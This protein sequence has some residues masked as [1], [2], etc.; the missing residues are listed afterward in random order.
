MDLPLHA[1]VQRD[2]R[3]V[4]DL[5]E[6]VFDAVV[7]DFVGLLRGSVDVKTME[8]KERAL[9]SNFR[10]MESSA[11]SGRLTV[12]T[13]FDTS[14]AASARRTSLLNSTLTYDSPSSEVLSIF[15]TPGI[16]AMPSSMAW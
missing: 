9:T 4:R 7:E 12:R 14:S 2:L 6:A 10:T 8:R 11:S 5:G 15:R 1:A 13:L 3:D 16:C